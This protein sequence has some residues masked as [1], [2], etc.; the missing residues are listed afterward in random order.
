MRHKVEGELN[1]L[2]TE[3]TLEPVDYANWAAPKVAMMKSDQKSMRVCGDFRMTVN[4]VSKLNRYPIPKVEVLFATL[5]RGKMFTKLDLSQAYQQLKL[6]TESRKYVVINTH[7]GLFHYTHL[8]Y[9][10]SSAPGI[11]QKAME[12]LLQGITHVTV[13]IDDILIMG[14]TESD[15]L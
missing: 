14:E 4:P 8:P 10:I 11:F 7:K 9:G 3:G 15:H 5:E 2:V 6:D 1:R 13:Y 12:S